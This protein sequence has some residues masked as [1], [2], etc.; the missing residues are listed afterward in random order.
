MIDLQRIKSF[1]RETLGCECPEEVF[2][3]IDCERGICPDGRV[4]LAG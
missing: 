2:R 1:V 4:K 3:S